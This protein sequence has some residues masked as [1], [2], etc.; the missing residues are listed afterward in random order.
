[1]NTYR[2]KVRDPFNFL[3]RE[4]AVDAPDE[5]SAR[6]IALDWATRPHSRC[7][8]ELVEGSGGEA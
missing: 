8:L 3:V 5:E 1:M 2:F 7:E 6:A 4:L